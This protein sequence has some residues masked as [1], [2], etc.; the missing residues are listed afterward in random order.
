MECI[1]NA[2]AGYSH[3]RRPERSNKYPENVFEPQIAPRVGGST[4]EGVSRG[5][6]EGRRGRAEAAGSLGGSAVRSAG[7]T[8]FTLP[9]RHPG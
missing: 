5:P 4:R 6:A 3:V 8:Q 9:C 1:L 7:E 2:N